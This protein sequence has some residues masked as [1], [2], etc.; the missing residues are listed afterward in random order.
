MGDRPH[1]AGGMGPF[2]DRLTVRSTAWAAR[3]VTER[4]G[5]DDARLLG[6]VD[7]NGHLAPSALRR[8]HRWA[9]E[10][11]DG[12]ATTLGIADE[13]P[14][15]FVLANAYVFAY[16]SPCVVHLGR[17]AP[18]LRSLETLLPEALSARDRKFL[19]VLIRDLHHAIWARAAGQR[20][21]TTGTGPPASGG[22]RLGGRAGRTCAR[23]RGSVPMT[24][25]GARASRRVVREVGLALR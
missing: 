2:E 24:A 9:V 4:F 22:P 5:C 17:G 21:A 3:D 8:L 16:G 6:Y 14:D 1:N 25:P 23:A 7:E 11:V 10:L 18:V 20:P 15:F 13:W 12:A 19:L